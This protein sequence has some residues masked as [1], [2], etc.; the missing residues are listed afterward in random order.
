MRPDPYQAKI[1]KGMII[2]AWL[3]LLGL[4]AFLFDRYLDAQ[5]N[6]NQA[7]NAGVN[8]R[9]KTVTLQRNRAGHYVAPARINGREVSVLLDTGATYISI[10]GH[11]A[12]KLN[13]RRGRRYPVT[14]ANGNVD[15]FATVLDSVQI[16]GI[17]Q[18]K[19]RA[20]INP[21]MYQDDV[22]MGMNFLKK[23][24]LTQRGDQ[25]TLRQ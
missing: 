24:E 22:L 10:P 12:K 21:A 20:N 6:P 4:M 13:L 18:K 15:V 3:L 11:V 2:G 5:H 25:L 1:G 8:V 23:L 16:G 14:T 9:D 17:I 19:V 7:L